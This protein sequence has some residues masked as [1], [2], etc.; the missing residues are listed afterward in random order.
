MKRTICAL[1]VIIAIVVLSV[2]SA[3]AVINA[4]A[5]VNKIND[6]VIF[7]SYEQWDPHMDDYDGHFDMTQISNGV[8][9]IEW[10]VLEQSEN[11]LLLLSKYP[12]DYQQF[13]QE[14]KKGTWKTSSIRNWLNTTFIN[15]AF[16]SEEKEAIIETEISNGGYKTIKNDWYQVPSET[17][18][19]KIFLLSYW[20]VNDYGLNDKIEINEYIDANDGMMFSSDNSWWTR[21]VG[22][23]EDEACYVGHGKA[24]SGWL[25][26]WRCIRPAMWIDKTLVDWD[27][28]LYSKAVQASELAEKGE[29]LDAYAI[30]DS[31]PDYWNGKCL[32]AAYRTLYAQQA[33]EDSDYPL[34]IER[35]AEARQYVKDHYAEK[36]ENGINEYAAV[37]NYL[38]INQKLLECRYQLAIQKKE[39]SDYQGAIALFT[40]VGQYE[41]SMQYLR[42]CFDKMH[43]Q[44]SWLTSPTEAINAGLDKEYSESNPITSNDPH[45]GWS[46]GRFMISGFTEE[47]QSSGRRIFMKTPGDN[48]VLWFDLNQ[49]IDSLNNDKN[50]TI[51]SDTD[52]TDRQFQVAKSNNGFGRGTLLI[53][54]TDFR[55]SVTPAQV[56]RDYLLANDDTGADTKVELK[57]EGIYEVALDYEI[58]KDELF[59]K[60]NDYRI[61]FTFEVRNGSG[62]FFMFDV[63]TGTELQDYSRTSDGFRIDLANSH[64]LSVSYTR[65]SLNQDE[66]ALDVRKTGL[67]S[68]GE[69]F[70]KVGYYEITVTNTETTEQLVKHIFVGRAADLEDYQAVDESLN[71][72]SK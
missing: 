1:A 68:D 20:E 67:A 30:T 35:F 38:G 5:D 34:A 24:E 14:R 65:Y 57:E 70:E 69:T 22:R 33:A 45:F 52:G 54:H 43:I 16:T 12:L 21:S 9:P 2:S 56:Y 13:N 3:F 46:L 71:K 8:E 28:S 49:D 27:N 42:E 47:K 25:S 58:K 64:S 50:L 11:K 23:K 36:N 40:D 31:I 48:L 41:N 4:P 63:T 17:T 26:D 51:N 72:F 29:Y 44:Y 61:S 55:N 7:G 10:I 53:R 39:A 62:M 15:K 66:T 6:C 19:D 60:Y 37:M 18:K 59:D 32:S